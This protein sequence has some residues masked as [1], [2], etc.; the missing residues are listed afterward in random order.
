METKKRSITKSIVWRLIA[1]INGVLGA[2]LFTNNFFQS[3]KIGVFANIT[4]FILYYFH[5]RLWNKI[6][7]GKYYIGFD[8]AKGEDFSILTKNKRL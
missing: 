7:W 8:P 5:E 2:L 1:T 4:G 6:K 3:L